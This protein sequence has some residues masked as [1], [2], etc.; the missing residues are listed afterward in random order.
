MKIVKLIL[1]AGLLGLP[2]ALAQA[3]LF[4]GVVC[5]FNFNAVEIKS[6]IQFLLICFRGRTK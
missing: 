4:F 3:G 6:G 1:G 2:Y 5:A